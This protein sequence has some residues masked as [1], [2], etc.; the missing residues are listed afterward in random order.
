MID[1]IASAG[2]NFDNAIIKVGNGN[3]SDLG[4]RKGCKYPAKHKKNMNS[5]TNLRSRKWR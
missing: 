4:R 3:Q 5:D 2:K 1:S